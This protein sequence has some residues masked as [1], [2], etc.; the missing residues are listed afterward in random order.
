[1]V[2]PRQLNREQVLIAALLFALAAWGYK[3]YEQRQARRASEQAVQT[4]R[5]I[6]ETA[7]L[8]AF[9]SAKGLRKKIRQLKETLPSTVI[10]TFTIKR[11]KTVI[12]LQEIDGRTLNRFLRRLGRLPVQFN[13]LSIRGNTGRYTL[14]CQ[15]KW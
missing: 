15:C 5:E 1:M 6:R 8:R 7:A 10:K 4:I 11:N 2:I 13:T 3:S 12:L 9:W 14:E